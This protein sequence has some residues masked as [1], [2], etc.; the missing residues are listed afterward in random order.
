MGWSVRAHGGV[1]LCPNKGFD[2]EELGELVYDLICVL[3]VGVVHIVVLTVMD[4]IN[5]V[6]FE[7]G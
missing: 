6:I 4:A 2:T 3:V 7:R 1:V 5:L